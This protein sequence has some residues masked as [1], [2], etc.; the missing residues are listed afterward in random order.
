MFIQPLLEGPLWWVMKHHTSLYPPGTVTFLFAEI[1]GSTLLLSQ[2]GK[3][4]VNLLAE[5]HRL[6]RLVF[7]RHS[8]RDLIRLAC[9]DLREKV[10]DKLDE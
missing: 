5:R 10:I 1:E 8:G 7:A 9:L 6:L 2:L 3:D 4:Y